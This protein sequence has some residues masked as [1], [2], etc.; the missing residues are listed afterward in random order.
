VVSRE[1]PSEQDGHAGLAS[2]HEAQGDPT[3]E[4]AESARD[5]AEAKTAEFLLRPVAASLERLKTS[6]EQTTPQVLLGDLSA[7]EASPS[8]IS[9]PMVGSPGAASPDFLGD[10]SPSAILARPVDADNIGSAS[11][12]DNGIGDDILLTEAL[13]RLQ[14]QLGTLEAILTEVEGSPVNACSDKVA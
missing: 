7:Q 9:E 4:D 13:T 11:R 3:A 6:I 10:L 8:P 12:E 5:W 2:G 1:K 14:G